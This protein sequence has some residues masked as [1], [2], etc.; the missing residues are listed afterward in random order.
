MDKKN[1]HSHSVIHAKDIDID[2][3][4]NKNPCVIEYNILEECLIENDRSWQKCREQGLSI[5]IWMDVIDMNIC[6]I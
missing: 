6:M 2:E 4:I 1:S 5:N 3:I